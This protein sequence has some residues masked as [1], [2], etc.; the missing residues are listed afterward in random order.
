[1]KFLLLLLVASCAQVT[2]LNLKKHSFGVLP[3][4]IIW[5]QVAGLEEEQL[6]MLRYEKMAQNRTAFESNTCLGKT[7]SYNLFELRPKA[8][9][10]FLSEL[11]GKNN[12][13]HSCEDTKHRPIWSY[14]GPNGY[15]T[16]V[17]EIGAN[18][19][20]SLTNYNQ[21]GE[22]GL[23]FLS[24]L[25]YWLRAEPTPGAE[26]FHYNDPIKMEPNQFV[27]DRACTGNVCR[28]T[29]YEDV[30]AIYDQFR[31]VS[32]KHMMIVRDFSYLEALEKKDLTKAR[33]I[34][35]DIERSYDYALKVTDNFSDVLILL[36]SAESRYLELPAQGKDWYDLEKVTKGSQVHPSK[37]TNL[38]LATGARAE[39]FCGIYESEQIFTRIL[40][41][42]KQQ[43]LEL[44]VINP[45]K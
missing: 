30:K 23:V 43:G 35:K 40:T 31:F 34:L 6:A 37:L 19:E 32:K 7:W 16:G 11:T 25:Y 24:S 44:K 1:M 29:I 45:F 8:E 9:S 21:C 22:N 14:L 2:S 12:I 17:L 39:N 5:F 20:Q 18:K 38:V 10:V 4:K 42:P 3:T 26:T 41:G 36:T 13:K 28:S 27:Y 33:E 15:N